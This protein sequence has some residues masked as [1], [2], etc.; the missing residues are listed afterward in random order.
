MTQTH[1]HGRGRRR[2]MKRTRSVSLC[3]HDMALITASVLGTDQPLGQC[4]CC[5]DKQ[6][7]VQRQ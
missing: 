7:S 6:V 2:H 5:R 4:R 1:P 3:H